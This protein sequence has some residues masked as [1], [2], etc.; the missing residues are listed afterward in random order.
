VRKKTFLLIALPILSSCALMNTPDT[1]KTIEINGTS[2]DRYALW[3]CH[4][5]YG[6][7][8]IVFE[9]VNIPDV[10]F[11]E[12]A[13]EGADLQEDENLAKARKALKESEAVLANF[14]TDYVLFGSRKEHYSA[15]YYRHG[16]NHRWDWEDKFSFVIKPDG[17]GLYY[18]FSSTQEGE[19][20]TA[21]DLFKCKLVYD[22]I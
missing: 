21:S 17:T 12:E 10:T 20:T 22:N 15:F 6:E 14:Y 18:D 9:F 2:Y 13:Q 11:E 4:E 1:P 16:I 5:F 3:E 19:A 7:K 8:N